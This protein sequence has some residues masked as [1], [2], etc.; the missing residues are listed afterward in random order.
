MWLGGDISVNRSDRDSK[1]GCMKRCA[2][3]L[4][5]DYPVCIL[6]EGTRSGSN[7]MLEFKDGAF[8][9]AIE[10]NCDILPLAIAGSHRAIPLHSRLVYPSKARV[11]V[12]KPISTKGMTVDDVEK[13]KNMA[14]DQIKQLMAVIVPICSQ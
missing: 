2:D 1:K 6:P 7:E 8:R 13:L 10:N 12:G 3:Y 4:Q 9:L 14:K 11:I 5:R